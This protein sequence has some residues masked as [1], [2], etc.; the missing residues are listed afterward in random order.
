MRGETSAIR[1]TEAQKLLD[2]GFSNFEYVECGKKDDIVKTLTVDKGIFGKVDAVLNNDINCLINKGNSKNI[3]TT[4]S[5]DDSIC[6]PIVKG[7]K[8]GE[9]NYSIDDSNIG[10]VDIV[11]KEDVKKISFI[12]MFTRLIETWFKLLR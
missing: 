10:T 5:L 12:N 1:F 6:A 9:I 8:I 7:Q 2:Y 4:I 11:A 3:S